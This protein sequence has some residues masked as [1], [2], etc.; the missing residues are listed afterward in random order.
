MKSTQPGRYAV[1]GNP[2]AHSLSP[3]IHAL[4]SAQTAIPL[5][6]KRLLSP[7]HAFTKT[8]LDFFATGGRGLNV[9]VP[10]KQQA[11]ALA[12]PHLSARAQHAAAVNTLWEHNGAL[13]GCNTDG[14][15][16][17]NDLTRLNVVLE[18]A[19]LL[20]IGAGGAAR[21]VLPALAQA[22]SAH[23]HI[24]NRT[25]EHAQALADHWRQ[26]ASTALPTISA[27]SLAEARIGGP[28]DI[29][30]N[31][32][33]SGLQG[34]APALPSGLYASRAIAYD[35]M[36]KPFLTPF[37]QQAQADGAT[38]SV[39]GLGM[40]ISQAAESFFLWHGVRPN[41]NPVLIQLQQELTSSSA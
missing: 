28:W 40:L 24:V 20:L 17:V 13:Y 3:R 11:H 38:I 23:L 32:T 27:G 4:F 34:A 22:G 14:V 31:A 35:M 15:G 21:G 29:V 1:I 37:M 30:I 7:L 18:D 5:E 2:I 6:Y 36:Y 39:N 33:A 9:T 8:V 19:R 25:P 10:F 12:T 41:I 26:T 16:L